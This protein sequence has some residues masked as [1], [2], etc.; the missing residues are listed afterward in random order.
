MNDHDKSREQLVGELMELRQRI[1]EL[2]TAQREHKR[3]EA[4]LREAEE[5][6]RGIAENAMD[7]VFYYSYDPDDYGIKYINR[8]IEGVIGYVP[9]QYYQDP[10]LDSKVTHPD[11]RPVLAG[12]EDVLR[13]T[14]QPLTR[15][16]RFVHRDGHTV[17]VE[18]K[19]APIFNSEGELVA[20]VGVSRDITERRRA[21][22]Q[23]AHMA[24]HDA[25]TGLPNRT[26]FNDRL[27]VA[28]AHAERNGQ[29]LAVML[30][31][32]DHFKDVNDTLRHSVGDQLLQ[33]VG[34]RLTSLLRKSDTVAR[35]GGD[36]FLLLF[37]K[38]ARTEYSARIASKIVEAFRRPFVFDDHE[39]HIT[40]SIGIAVYPCDGEDAD[41]LLRNADI[42]MYRGKER[43]RNTYQRYT[44]D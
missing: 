19:F 42:A 30:L 38:L 27:T 26:L 2:E 6:Y 12:V 10:G 41:T 5:R 31:D 4:A 16:I 18:A 28:L 44:E 43:G 11:D 25:L 36:E 15:Q 23:L 20:C 1:A 13:V 7:V 24:T 17:H 32:L 40:T 35:M 39:L 3:I 22:E 21:E 8:A 29:K 9:E 37:P 14:R 34:N 33:V